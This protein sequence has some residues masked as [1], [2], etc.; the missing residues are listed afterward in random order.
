MLPH[1]SWQLSTL[2]PPRQRNEQRSCLHSP[3]LAKGAVT[4]A[5]C[6]SSKGEP[7]C[8]SWDL[9]TATLSRD[10]WPS[11]T[12]YHLAI[13][14]LP[15]GRQ[16]ECPEPPCC[17]MLPAQCSAALSPGGGS[18][19]HSCCPGHGQCCLPCHEAFPCTSARL[20]P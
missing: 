13:L 10:C 19:V 5:A 16:D 4:G 7:S 18:S 11:P 3:C 8:P 9:V 1:P 20:R 14:S 6:S 12:H 17:S 2:Q 15:L